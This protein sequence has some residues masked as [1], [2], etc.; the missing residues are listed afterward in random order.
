M[1]KAIVIGTSTGVGRAL[2]FKLNKEGYEVGLTGRCEGRLLELQKEISGKTYVKEI[3]VRIPEEA[4]LRLEELIQEMGGLDL[5]IVNAGVR[6]P[7][8][9]LNWEIENETCRVNAVGFV[10]T[11]LVGMRH[12]LSKNSGHLVGISSIAG[13]RGAEEAPA[14]NATKAFMS[15][16]LEGLRWKTTNTSVQVTDILLGFVRTQMLHGRKSSFLAISPERASDL[17][18]RAIRERKKRTYVP[19]RWLFLCSLFQNLP[20][21]LSYWFYWKFT[22]R[23]T[24]KQFDTEVSLLN[25]ND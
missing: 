21:P 1:K 14:Y 20:E 15:N 23:Q 8:L 6:H 3:D 5:L 24:Q 9:E 13:L 22:S 18:F 17:I 19:L 25:R 4:S 10:A 2:A 7:N 12:F 16:Y 11:A